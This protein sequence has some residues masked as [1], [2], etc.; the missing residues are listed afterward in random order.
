MMKIPSNVAKAESSP[1]SLSVQRT[2][3]KLLR[4]IFLLFINR[5]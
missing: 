3:T 5:I 2:E 1:A 4:L